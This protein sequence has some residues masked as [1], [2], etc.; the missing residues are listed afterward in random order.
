MLC[1]LRS[2]VNQV[3]LPTLSFTPC[4]QAVAPPGYP[5]TDRR[6]LEMPPCRSLLHTLPFRS[7]R[8]EWLPAAPPRSLPSTPTWRYRGC[9]R[10][11]A[12]VCHLPTLAGASLLEIEL[13]CNPALLTSKLLIVNE[14]LCMATLELCKLGRTQTVLW[15]DWSRERSI[16]GSSPR[17]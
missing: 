7:S 11:G 8:P 12:W 10:V 14:A 13:L 6:A 2:D 9:L 3:P 15:L 17:R 5:V 4:R 1:T 16:L